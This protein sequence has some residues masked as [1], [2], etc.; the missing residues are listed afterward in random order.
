VFR[1]VE[2]YLLRLFED[3]IESTPLS[4]R[5]IKISEGISQFSLTLG[6]CTPFWPCQTTDKNSFMQPW[7][8]IRK[9]VRV[10]WRTSDSWVSQS[11][12]TN[13]CTSSSGA[14]NWSKLNALVSSLSA[15][16]GLQ[17]R[18]QFS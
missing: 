11:V 10:G 18:S 2:K 12:D 4:W 15:R 6:S 9:V 1:H 14:A 5:E 16:I 17:P 8:E 3:S 13:L 7:L